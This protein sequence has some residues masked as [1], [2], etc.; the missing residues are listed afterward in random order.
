MTLSVIPIVLI[1]VYW[2]QIK[3]LLPVEISD[4]VSTLIEMRDNG[5]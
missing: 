4:N 1:V 2:N 3:Q 5:R